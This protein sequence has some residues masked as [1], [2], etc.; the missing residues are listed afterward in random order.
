MLA[1][2]VIEAVTVVLLLNVRFHMELQAGRP[3]TQRADATS[4]ITYVSLSSPA[5]RV[6]LAHVPR[7]HTATS[8]TGSPASLLPVIT[9]DT[10]I[11][12]PQIVGSPRSAPVR[13]AIDSRIFKPGSVGRS[14]AA[15]IDSIIRVGIQPGNDSLM[16]AQRARE[17][18]VDWTVG[19]GGERYGMSPGT[20]HLG[21][22]TLRAPVVFAEPLSLS[23]D[24][25]HASR[26]VVED[27]RSH[28]ARAI[29][30]AMFDSA[31]ASIARR[32]RWGQW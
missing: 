17:H 5:K 25:R 16:R 2:V 20:L 24:R 26:L 18:A 21:K 28:A 12:L 7:L 32:R 29:R 23:S 10:G 14:S 30:D 19:I 9:V 27:T 1:A 11:H 31:V 15:M 13:S 22:I 6:T 3:T 4:R 8:P